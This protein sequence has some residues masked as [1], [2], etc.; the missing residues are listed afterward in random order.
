MLFTPAQTAPGA[1]RSSNS[2]VAATAGVSGCRVCQ[3]TLDQTDFSKKQK[4]RLN[5]GKPATCKACCD[6]AGD[7]ESDRA[8]GAKAKIRA[9]EQ[10]LLVKKSV[11]VVSSVKHL[12]CT[13][14]DS[15]PCQA[16]YR[17]FLSTHAPRAVP[18]MIHTNLAIHRDNCECGFM[19]P[20]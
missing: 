6:D 1:T 19:L 20:Q 12:S 7:G 10:P 5:Q 18:S 15:G 4:K 11:T 17:T 2:G 9:S 14:L 13:H 16:V 8:G 3:K